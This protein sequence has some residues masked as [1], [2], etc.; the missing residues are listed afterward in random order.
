MRFASSFF[1]IYYEYWILQFDARVGGSDEV[2]QRLGIFADDGLG[3]VAA[4]VVPF[5]AVLVDVVED[6]ETGLSR[7]VDLEFGVVRLR[8]F[9]VTSGTPRLVA[10]SFRVGVGGGQFH[11]R[12]GP[13]PSVDGQR[14]QIIAVAS[15]EVAQTAAGPDVGQFL[16]FFLY[17]IVEESRDLNVWCTGYAAAYRAPKRRGPCRS[18]RPFRC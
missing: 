17:F 9:E 2:E 11:A 3:V 14:L 18:L 6:A 12:T 4:N 13:E 7:L 10:P 15:L 16:C 8:S 1:C 5:N